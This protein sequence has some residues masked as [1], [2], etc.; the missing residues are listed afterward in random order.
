MDSICYGLIFIPNRS[1]TGHPPVIPTVHSNRSSQQFI[2]TVHPPV[3]PT[4]HPLVIPTV[5]P[6]VIP[7]DHPLVIPTDHPLVIPTDH[8]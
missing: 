3:I 4:V 8:P 2:P 5:H 6:L 1:S 7:T